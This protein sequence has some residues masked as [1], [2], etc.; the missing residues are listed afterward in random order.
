MSAEGEVYE[1]QALE[2]V[3]L[4]IADLHHQE[5]PDPDHEHKLP[6]VCYIRVA[7]LDIRD[8]LQ[9]RYDELRIKHRVA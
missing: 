1:R 7:L 5:Q 6:D 2:L 9:P 3:L 4:A 8:Q